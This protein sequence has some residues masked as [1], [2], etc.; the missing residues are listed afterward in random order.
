MS[1][2]GF[3]PAVRLVAELVR[4][5]PAP[6]S[7][8][9]FGAAVYAGG[10]VAATIVLGRIVD[11]VVLPVLDGDAELSGSSI[12]GWAALVLVVAVLRIAGV[13][14]RRYFAGMTSERASRHFR[15]GLARSYVDLP[16]SFHRRRAAGDLLAHVD[17][18]TEV[19]VDVLHPVPFSLAVVM[20]AVFAAISM[21]L[22]DPLLALVA[23]AVFP[24]LIGFNRIY[25][26]R[27]EEP[28]ILQQDGIGRVATV[29]HESLDGAL[30]VKLLGRTDAEVERFA[31]EADALRGHRIRVGDLRAIFESVLDA[32]PN[33]GIAAVIVIGAWRVDQGAATV[34]GLVQVASLFAVLAFPMRVLGFFLESVPTS[35]AAKRRLESVLHEPVPDRPSASVPGGE[36][37]LEV[38]GLCAGYDRVS[39]L[40]DVSFDVRPGE[41]VALVGATGSGKSTIVSA[42]AGLLEP[43]AGSIRL[44]GVDL[45]TLDPADRADLVRIAFQ[46]SFLFA[47]SVASN[48]GL[49]RPGADDTE[50]GRVLTVARADEFVAALP[51][52]AATVVGERGLTLSGGQ[53][54]R[55]AL[56]R[57][58]VGEPR[59][60][61]L[62]DATSAVDAAIE[63]EILDALRSVRSS[64]G[65]TVA[66]P[67]MLVV[68]HR[69]STIRLADRVVF[70]R[71]GRVAGSGSHT[72]LLADPDYLALATAY[73]QTER[74]A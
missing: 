41:I 71:Q 43:T 62:D 58:F 20:M 64:D 33:L 45:A 2:T 59:V 9:V 67:S 28:S 29:A 49:D 74:E 47:D 18:D 39:V 36:A 55:L 8:S 69:L 30:V 42:L 44:G 25:T 52:G 26:H 32:L 66:P 65:T 27:I 4:P 21:L 48:V 63:S 14:A 51:D 38:R 22:V 34:G 16:M 15:R 35:L 37:R 5:H 70:L 46:E 1:G 19:A 68:A 10:T 53:R 6:F 7:V 24:L 3:V 56:A 57:A 12:A 31:A 40:D 73:E 61:V 60:V 72:E 11:R 23:F 17:A 13:I 50:I 54:Q